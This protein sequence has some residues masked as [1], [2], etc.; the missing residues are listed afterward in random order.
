ML[1]AAGR[2]CRRSCSA[3]AS[4]VGTALLFVFSISLR[5]RKEIPN[6]IYIRVRLFLIFITIFAMVMRWKYS[7]TN[8]KWTL[9][10]HNLYT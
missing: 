2:R 5:K 1:R 6:C 8:Y 7:C 3:S 9:M 4:I 10:E